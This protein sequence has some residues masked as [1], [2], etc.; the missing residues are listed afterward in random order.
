MKSAQGLLKRGFTLIE[1]LVVIGI[2]AV[3]LAIVLIAIN[4]ARQFAQANDTQRRSD[5]NAI[6]N[7][8]D[9]AM[10]DLSGT[11]PAP[12]DTAPQ[13]TAIPFSSTDVISGTDTGTV[14]CQAIV[15]TYMA[16]I[17]KDPQT[18]S[19]NDCTNFD[20]GYTITVATGTGTPRVTVAAT[21][22]LATS[23]SVTR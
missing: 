3:L 11:L 4:P 9:Q 14:L 7:A 17:P 22:Q 13:G 21:P 20:T 15:P 10:V 1:L 6:L 19:W 16:Q 18:G 8:I 5:V 12:L 23:I 2:L